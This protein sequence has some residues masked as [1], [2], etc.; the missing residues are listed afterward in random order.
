MIHSDRE[1]S[2][3]LTIGK[4]VG[5]HGVRGEVKVELWTEHLE[6]FRP[7]QTVYLGD[8]SEAVTV[9]IASARPLP[10]KNLMLVS[11]HPCPTGRLPNCSEAA[12]SDSHRRGRSPGRARELPARSDWTESRDGQRGVAR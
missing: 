8:D 4:I 3:Y 7:G 2:E 5:V 9:Q 6:R 10:G 1:E 12:A 11:W